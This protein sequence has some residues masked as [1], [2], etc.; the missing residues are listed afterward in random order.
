[1]QFLGAWMVLGAALLTGQGVASAEQ[2]PAPFPPGPRALRVGTSE[3][4]AAADFDAGLAFDIPAAQVPPGS[5]VLLTP[6]YA[7]KGTPPAGAD[8]GFSV[9]YPKGLAVEASNG[10]CTVS[11]ATRTVHCTSPAEGARPQ[12][13]VTVDPA[14][15]AG[16]VLDLT[17][18]VD[19]V[20]GDS[21][22]SDDVATA[23]VTVVPLEAHVDVTAPATAREG[24]V[25]TVVVHLRNDGDVAVG[26]EFRGSVIMSDS[27]PG[28]GGE[29]FRWVS[30][31][32]TCGTDP[33]SYQCG[34][35][36]TVPPGGTKTYSFRLEALSGAAGRVFTMS[37]R[38]DPTATTQLQDAVRVRIL[39]AAVVARPVAGGAPRADTPVVPAD[40]APARPELAATGSN[41]VLLGLLGSGLLGVGLV[42]R[43]L[44]PNRS[45]LPRTPA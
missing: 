24:Q 18:T 5:W 16:Q 40:T 36:G 9:T 10:Q 39:P 19:P 11:A 21:D 29:L 2:A 42:L 34:A 41:G 6:S 1:M 22:P 33:A 37:A 17:A 12:M 28:G 44:G 15:A 20:P 4:R 23:T 25:F 38:W 27:G 43:R 14:A 13:R 8:L 7:V 26:D 30:L 31:P 32:P 35:G 45:R 3:V